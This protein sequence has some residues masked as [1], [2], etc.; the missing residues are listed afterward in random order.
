MP[1]QHRS[2]MDWTIGPLDYWTISWAIFQTN[3]WTS[4][5]TLIFERL[6]RGM[7]DY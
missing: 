6:Y 1:P 4:F 7:A 2:N 5:W 3:F